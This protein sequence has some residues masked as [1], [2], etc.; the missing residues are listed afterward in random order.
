MKG[1]ECWGI[2]LSGQESF[3]GDAVWARIIAVAEGMNGPSF[4]R[5]ELMALTH[6]AGEWWIRNR[7]HILP[8]P[9]DYNAKSQ[10]WIQEA[11]PRDKVNSVCIEDYSLVSHPITLTNSNVCWALELKRG[12]RCDPCPQ[13]ASR[14]VIN[15]RQSHT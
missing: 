15:V 3:L 14:L 7:I 6:I 10:V 1:R 8:I 2:V 11:R 9:T 4:Y 12:Q 5:C 13:G